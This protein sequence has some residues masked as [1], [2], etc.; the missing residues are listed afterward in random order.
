MI[1]RK[2]I[3]L[4]LEPSRTG[5]MTAAVEVD[6]A[7]QFYLHS[8]YDPQKEARDWLGAVE[9]SLHTMYIVLGFGLGYHVRALLEALPEGC[10][11]IVIEPFKDATLSA[12]V[13]Q[14]L[15]DSAWLK[16]S[17]LKMAYHRMVREI[18]VGIAASL[19]ENHIHRVVMCPHFPSMQMYPDFYQDVQKGLS[20]ELQIKFILQL[21][22]GI[23]NSRFC[24]E[25]AWRN[26]PFI[27]SNPGI[28]GLKDA[29]RNRPVIIVSSGP[30]LNKNIDILRDCGDRALIIACG[31]ALMALQKKGITPHILGS[32][33]PF[34]VTSE[35]LRGISSPD[36][37]L[38][39]SYD[40]AYELVAEHPGPMLFPWKKNSSNLTEFRP[41]LPLTDSLRCSVSVTT[42]V[43]DFALYIGAEPI[44]MVG[45]DCAYYDMETTHADGVQGG[46]K[47]TSDTIFEYV[48]GQDGSQLKTSMGFKDVLE[49]I[50]DFI[51]IYKDKKFIN[52]SEGGALINGAEHLALSEVKR[53]YLSNSFDVPSLLMQHMNQFQP[54][55]PN[56]ILLKLTDIRAELL[57]FKEYLSRA[58]YAECEGADPRFEGTLTMDIAQAIDLMQSKQAY[59]FIQSIMDPVVAYVRFRIRDGLPEKEK[60]DFLLLLEQRAFSFLNGLIDWIDQSLVL[61]ESGTCKS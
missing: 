1:T 60:I 16:D 19:N 12:V 38:L 53:R 52:A 27:F 51:A 8:L 34:P 43:L 58:F 23:G 36:T 31:S 14:V 59:R 22:A 21:N 55:D 30:S 20:D 39:A 57:E 44:I 24:I 25:N 18:A 50:Q 46:E 4:N 10:R 2:K 32:V 37:L 17:R 56:A 33:D 42:T 9:L 40:T 15:P 47:L 26:L 11:I 49:F 28:L 29:Y 35:T 61:L 6:S 48:E 13:D 45:Q 41:Y 5:A 54:A 7:P 3:H